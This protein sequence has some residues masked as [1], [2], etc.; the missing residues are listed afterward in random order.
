MIIFLKDCAKCKGQLEYHIDYMPVYD[1][2][3]RGL[4]IWIDFN[5]K[6]KNLSEVTN[7]FAAALGPNSTDKKSRLLAQVLP[8]NYSV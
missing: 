5:Y 8:F 3:K 2:H 1:S 6:N 4:N 7:I